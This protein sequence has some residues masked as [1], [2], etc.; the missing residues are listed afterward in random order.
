M[1]HLKV[2]GKSISLKV[3]RQVANAPE[4]FRK[5]GVGYTIRPYTILYAPTSYT[6]LH[7]GVLSAPFPLLAQKA[8]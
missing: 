8:P 6:P 1:D 2:C 7:S 5:G 3:L 4:N